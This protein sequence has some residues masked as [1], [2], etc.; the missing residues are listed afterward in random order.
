MNF[1]QLTLSGVLTT[2]LLF[3]PS[4]FIF[5]VSRS[6]RATPNAADSELRA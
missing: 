5:G 1:V 3:I 4:G 6:A 2:M